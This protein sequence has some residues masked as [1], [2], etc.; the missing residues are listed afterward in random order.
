MRISADSLTRLE[1]G[2]ETRIRLE[3]FPLWQPGSVPVA[4]S[5]SPNQ[6]GC[7]EIPADLPTGPWW[8][9]GRDGDWMRFRP[10]LWMVA[11]GETPVVADSALAAAVCKSDPAQRQQ[12]LDALLTELRQ[13]PDH[14]DWPLLFGYV[15]LA[16]EFPPSALDI[17]CRLAIRPRTLA[18]ALMK[19]DDETFEPMWAL[20][21]QMPFWWTL[22]AVNDWR[23]GD[24]LFWRTSNHLGRGGRQ[25][26]KSFS[27][28]S[29]DS[30]NGPRCVAFIGGS[31]ATG[32]KSSCFPTGN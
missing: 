22:L 25:S 7:W 30:G 15:R 16:R 26:G 13:N 27:V 19:A 21:R 9:V 31:C 8:I 20:S 32:S 11:A 2:W 24:G 1:A 14:A 3:T 18:L 6:P 4:L 5:A 28:C 29:R 10:L 17:L 12:K 23:S